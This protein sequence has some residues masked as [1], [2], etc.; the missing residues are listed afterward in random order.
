[1]AGIET[2]GAS[3]PPVVSIAVQRSLLTEDG[4]TASTAGGGLS[5]LAVGG[6]T[7]L[8][9]I[10]FPGELAMAVFCRGCPWRCRY[11]HNGH[12]LERRLSPDI[13]WADVLALLHRR[14]G[15]LDG[16]VFSGGEP[17]AQRGLPGAVREVRALGFNVA[18]HTAGCYPGRLDELLP[19]L[20]WVGLDIKAL[21][22]D[23]ARLTGVPGS[24]E[25][26]FDSLRRLLESGVRH[27]V[28]VT[29]H[30]ALLPPVKL[31]RLIGLLGECGVSDPVLQRCRSDRMLDPALGGNTL[32]WPQAARCTTAE[33]QHGITAAGSG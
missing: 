9:T 33:W 29:V 23:Y 18:L 22:E 16:V 4:Y 2:P 8:T 19:A 25:R 15:L 12:L 6:V 3:K 5:V 32:P 7:P 27:E 10:D 14:R 11:C 30:D 1:M 13:A 24:D 21:P 26:A 20:D 17:T 28:R 31:Q